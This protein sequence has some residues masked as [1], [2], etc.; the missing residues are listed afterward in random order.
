[1]IRKYVGDKK[2]IEA[3]SADGKV[4]EGK[5]FDCGR[6]TKFSQ[7]SLAEVDNLAAKHHMRLV[8]KLPPG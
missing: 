3:R 2:S 4:W 8:S 1:M 5:L 7:A 6:Q